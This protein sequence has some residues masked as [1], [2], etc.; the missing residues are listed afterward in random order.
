MIGLP[1]SGCST[2]RNARRLKPSIANAAQN[3]RNSLSRVC[4]QNLKKKALAAREA[5]TM[6]PSKNPSIMSVALEYQAVQQK[7]HRKRRDAQA[8]GVEAE[9]RQQR[10]IDEEHGVGRREPDEAQAAPQQ[11][12]LP[13]AHVGP[14]Q[15]EGAQ[16][17]SER[18]ENVDD[19]L[20]RVT[21]PS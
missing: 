6:M 7:Q 3:P 1:S 17:D 15:E 11:Q 2:N 9:L 13:D 14:Q 5:V 8:R 16:A 10:Q 4:L 21:C 19:G 18:A 20:H 12:S